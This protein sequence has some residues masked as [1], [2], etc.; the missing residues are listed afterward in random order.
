VGACFFH[1]LNVL[2]D[3]R[4]RNAKKKRG[5]T[6]YF[7]KDRQAASERKRQVAMAARIK[8]LKKHKNV[9]S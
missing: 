9:G 8:I 3:K 1:G 6:E 2:K 7:E 4:R 5:G